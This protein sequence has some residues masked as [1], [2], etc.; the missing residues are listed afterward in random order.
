MGVSGAVTIAALPVAFFVIRAL[1]RSPLGRR[2]VAEPTG[3]R[4][5]GSTT[6][7]FG[8]IGIYCGFLVG[9]A[10]AVLTGVLEPTT[11]LLG[12]RR[13]LHGD[14]RRGARGR[15]VR[16]PA[17]GQAAGAIRRRR[18]RRSPAG[19][20]VELFTNDVVAVIVARRLAR[21]HHERLQPPRQHGRARGHARHGRLRVLRDRLRRACTTTSSSSFW[22]SRSDSPAS[23]FLPYNL[24]AGKRAAVFMGDG[25]SQLLGF[26]LASIGLAASWTAAGTTVAT[27]MLPLIVLAIPIL[28]TTLVTIV[29]VLERRPV[30]QG[31]QGP[32]L[33]PP[34]L[35]RP[36]RA[37]GRGAARH[38]R[39]RARRD[40]A[41]PTTSSTTVASRRSVSSS[42]SSSSSSSATS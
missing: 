14:L 26:G 4:W 8:G 41:S 35:L 3:E 12:D 32:H 30:T 25:G 9:V 20:H 33:A 10:A 40:R 7:T 34:R 24:R 19:L 23:G 18:D 37:R 38:R 28:D 42:A 21:R 39:R 13:R 11:E 1:L 5:H 17:A 29:R 6:P 27:V 16:P 22:R 15:R 2:L 36:L 31:G